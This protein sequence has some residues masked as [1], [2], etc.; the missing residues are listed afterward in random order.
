METE[1]AP[2]IFFKGNAR[3]AFEFYQSVFGGELK[4]QTNDQTPKD[5]QGQMGVND[6]NRNQLMHARLEGGLV[7]LM[8][9]D[10]KNASDHS[11]KVELSISGTDEA[12][13]KEVF[14]KLAA[15]GEVRMPLSE[16]FWG[17]T[18]GMLTDK[19]G[20]DWMFNISSAA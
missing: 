6:E 13:L 20:V 1:L 4:T 19:Y 12:K 7:V 11:A 18:F 15:G 14:S 2:Y 10:S 5:V 9:S 16:Q 17:D 3:E 8:G